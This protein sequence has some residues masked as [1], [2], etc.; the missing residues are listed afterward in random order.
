MATE[1]GARIKMHRQRA[2]MSRPVL[3]GLLTRSPEWLKKIESGGLLPPRLPML[4][5]IAQ[6]LHVDIAD[7]V[8][9][10]DIPEGSLSTG[11]HPALPAVR[12]AIAHLPLRADQAPQPIGH[13]AARV[14]AGW[15]IRHASPDHR[16]VLGGLLPALIRDAQY[17]AHAATGAERRRAQAALAGVYCL[18]Q[19]FVA[20][21]PDAPLVWRVVDRAMLAAREA[22]SPRAIAA[23]AWLHVEAYREAGDWDT[24]L[25]V[26][27]QVIG[28]LAPSDD[29]L[30]GLLGALHA[31]AA[32][33]AARAGSA[34]RAQRHLDQAE[35]IARRTVGTQPQT[36]FSAPIVG[37][38]AVAVSLELRRPGEAL[39][40]AKRV[41]PATITSVPRRARHHLEVARAHWLRHQGRDALGELTAGASTAPETIA[42]SPIARRMV[43]EMIRD[44]SDLGLRRD[45]RDLAL[46]MMMPLVD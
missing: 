3:A 30:L 14:A 1:V 18:T 41:D 7:L 9:G 24:A 11:G 39:Q 45:A 37:H 4:S 15:R 5:R 42:Y 17:T 20:Y 33:T 16:S 22:D 10:L 29:D 19:M 2:G 27:D 40:A 31:G 8:G 34:G 23:A 36:W 6:V 25:A 32:V 43:A 28:Y 12:A 26:A 46:R 13:I 38:Y 44:Q 35:R 21:Q